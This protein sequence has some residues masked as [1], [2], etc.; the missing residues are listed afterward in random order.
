MH[1]RMVRLAQYFQNLF[2]IRPVLQEVDLFYVYD[3]DGQ[4]IVGFEEI[5][6]SG[7]DLFQVFRG[8]LL[9]VAS[10]TF[11]DVSHQVVNRT[12]QVNQQV[13]LRESGVEDV[14][15]ALE[16]TVLFLHEVVAGEQKRFKK[17]I[18]G[19]NRLLKEVPLGE[20]RLQ[21]LVALG[22]EEKL[23]RKSISFGVL[24]KMGQEG[25]VRKFF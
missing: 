16:Q 8:Y 6:I 12:M 3:E 1:P 15:Q 11:A 7:L 23:H 19:D 5:K 17:Y 22:H 18:V 14:E 9:F 10:A 25:V 13:R 20:L 2:I 21:L 24:V 4:F